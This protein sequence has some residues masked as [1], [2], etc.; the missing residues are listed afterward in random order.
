LVVVSLPVFH[1]YWARTGVAIVIDKAAAT[2]RGVKLIIGYLQRGLG[3]RRR[4]FYSA[5]G[6]AAGS[7]NRLAVDLV[8]IEAFKAAL[9]RVRTS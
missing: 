4:D 9:V 3:H 6:R 5:D 1:E 2:I 7:M 8:A